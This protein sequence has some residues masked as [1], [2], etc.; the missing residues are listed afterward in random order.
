MDVLRETTLTPVPCRAIAGGGKYRE[1]SPE[2]LMLTGSRDLMAKRWLVLNPRKIL[3]GGFASDTAHYSMLL[4]PWQFNM[5]YGF[6]VRR[7]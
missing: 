2:G 6:P 1:R 5:S 4:M 7:R 3:T